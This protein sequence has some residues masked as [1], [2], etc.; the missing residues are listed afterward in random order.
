MNAKAM[1]PACQRKVFRSRMKRLIKWEAVRDHLGP[2][3]TADSTEGLVVTPECIDMSVDGD[4]WILR[5]ARLVHLHCSLRL[6]DTSREEATAACCATLP[7]SEHVAS[8]SSL[9]RCLAMYFELKGFRET[10]PK[11]KLGQRAHVR[12]RRFDVCYEDLVV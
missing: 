5:K 7:A 6:L 3:I 8:G 10:T 12:Q 9:R 4:Q 11:G 2:F 1:R